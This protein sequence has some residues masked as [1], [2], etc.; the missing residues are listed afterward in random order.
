MNTFTNLI[1][2]AVVLFIAATIATPSTAQIHFENNQRLDLWS[3]PGSLQCD[4]HAKLFLS[5]C[6]D[7]ADVTYFRLH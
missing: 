7:R 4:G 1:K 6:Y 3:V 5:N 2:S